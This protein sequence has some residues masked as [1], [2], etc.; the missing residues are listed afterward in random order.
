MDNNEEKRPITPINADYPSNSHKK[1]EAAANEEKRVEKVITGSVVKKKKTFGKKLAE[2]FLGDESR[3]VGEYIIHDVLIPATKEMVS[4]MIKGGIEMLLFGERRTRGTKRDRS[5]VSYGS[6]YKDDRR[7][8]D[9]RERDISRTGRARHDFDEIILE[10]RGEAEEVLARL[11]DLVYD[12]G[13]ASVADLYDLVGITGDFTDHKYGW[14]ELDTSNSYVSR[15]RGGYM[16]NL[17][18]TRPLT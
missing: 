1:K 18:R 15:V 16:I 5:Y 14:T 6:Y 9:R 13:M 2:S 4:E 7:D 17:P 3:N 11:S 10:N 12:Y 8:R